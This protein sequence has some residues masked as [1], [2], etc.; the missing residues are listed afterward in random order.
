VATITL[1]NIPAELHRELKKRAEE[2]HR[3]LNREILAT[4]KNATSGTIRLDPAKLEESV[5][6]ARSLF[7]RPITA[8]QI[9]RWKREDRL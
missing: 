9:D 5:R 8:R 7:R 2:H 4:L 3:S 6:R 1:K